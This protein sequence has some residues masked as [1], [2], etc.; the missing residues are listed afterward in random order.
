MV[1]LLDYE[2]DQ[3][4]QIQKPHP[5]DKEN[6]KKNKNNMLVPNKSNGLDMENLS[7]MQTLQEVTITIPIPPGTKSRQIV[8]E[9]KKKSLRVGFKGQPLFI[10]GSISKILKLMI[11]FGIWRT[12]S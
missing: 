4:N 12:K 2:E 1:I 5:L 10:E 11:A 9:I 7:W 8:H 6:I 3:N